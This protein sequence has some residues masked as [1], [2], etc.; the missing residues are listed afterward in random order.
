M[1]LKSKK[2]FKRY[3][4]IRSKKVAK[5]LPELSLTNKKNKM[6]KKM[7]LNL[8]K[9]PSFLNMKI[10]VMEILLGHIIQFIVE[11]I[12]LPQKNLAIHNKKLSKTLLKD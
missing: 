3:L 5:Y 2:F 8:W 11:T 4:K 10:F 6:P 7:S 12:K 1:I 9:M